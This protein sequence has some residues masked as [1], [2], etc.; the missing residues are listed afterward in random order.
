MLNVMPRAAPEFVASR[1]SSLQVFEDIEHSAT[2]DNIEA[3]SKCKN[4]S[5]FQQNLFCE[6]RSSF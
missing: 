4:D 6:V 2:H 5:Y 3:N 1:A